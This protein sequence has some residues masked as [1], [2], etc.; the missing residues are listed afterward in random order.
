MNFNVGNVVK[1][2]WR[3]GEKPGADEIEDLEKAAWYLKDEIERR[4][5]AKVIAEIPIS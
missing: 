4:K 5:A 1:Y 2:L 3:V